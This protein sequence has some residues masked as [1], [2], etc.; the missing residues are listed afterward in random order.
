MAFTGDV[1][2]AIFAPSPTVRATYGGPLC[3][4]QVIFLEGLLNGGDVTVIQG[5]KQKLV[6][7]DEAAFTAIM[8]AHHG[9]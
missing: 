5:F 4:E 9:V 7:M 1:A 6:L 8:E 3:G 2:C